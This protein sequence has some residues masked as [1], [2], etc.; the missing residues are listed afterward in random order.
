MDVAF[1]LRRGGRERVRRSSAYV[2]PTLVPGRDA[3]RH[4]LNTCFAQFSRDQFGVGRLVFQNEDAGSFAHTISPAFSAESAK[5]KSHFF[6][7]RHG[8]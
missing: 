4:E 8:V 6:L 5:P 2:Y 7:A 1:L 3:F